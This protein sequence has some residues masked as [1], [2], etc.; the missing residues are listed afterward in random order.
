MVKLD[1]YS[2]K[3][4][5]KGSTNL[6]ERFVEKENLPLLAQAI[7]V[8]EARLHPGLAKVKTRG[9]VI[10]STRKIYRQKGTG[11]ARHGAKSA[12][13]FVGGGVAHGPKGLKRSLSLPARMRKIALGAAL[14]MAAK[15]GKLLVVDALSDFKKTKEIA[16]LLKKIGG[17]RFTL[18][19]SDQNLQLQKL[20][21]N[22]SNI[23]II[24][25]RGLNAHGG[26]LG[27]TIILD[28]EALS[29]KQ[30]EIKEKASTHRKVTSK[31]TR[32]KTKRKAKKSKEK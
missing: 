1:V 20:A 25:F 22:I 19:L 5:K 9:E 10:A 17:S 27:G 4:I 26:Y 12:P 6:P 28:K 13:I 15:E 23:N 14:T 18:V 3:G 24:P 8:Y 21:R 29:P 30:V 2:A 16:A 11:G 31:V 7:R 32:V